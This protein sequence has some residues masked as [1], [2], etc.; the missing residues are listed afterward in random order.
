M[1]MW[2]C[3]SARRHVSWSTCN[4]CEPT[5]AGTGSG[6]GRRLLIKL[7]SQIWCGT[8]G[9]WSKTALTT[10]GTRRFCR[11]WSLVC[12]NRIN[13]CSKSPPRI[14]S[15]SSLL[16]TPKF[17]IKSNEIVIEILSGENETTT[18]VVTIGIVIFH[19]RE[20]GWPTNLNLSS[21]RGSGSVAALR[22][23]WMKWKWS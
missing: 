18:W 2:M 1:V 12:W 20:N 3:L 7:W 4:C 14:R 5:T 17:Y 22:T 23:C 6:T 19:S 11:C 15:T 16:I 21:H 8:T 9:S 13:G 10:H